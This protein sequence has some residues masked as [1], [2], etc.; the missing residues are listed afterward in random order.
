MILIEV[1]IYSWQKKRTGSSSL[2]YG[3]M[4]P[5]EEQDM[6]RCDV[7]L[8]SEDT[9]GLVSDVNPGV[10]TTVHDAMSCAIVVRDRHSSS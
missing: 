9:K 2:R 3:E 10:A 5:V 4:I 7:L 1:N 6:Q 8:R